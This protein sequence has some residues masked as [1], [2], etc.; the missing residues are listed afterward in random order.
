MFVALNWPADADGRP[1]TTSTIVTDGTSPRVWSYYKTKDEVFSAP[2]KVLSTGL[3]ATPPY[4]AAYHIQGFWGLM[5]LRSRDALI[6]IPARLYLAN[7]TM[8]SYL[9]TQPI[10]KA[11]GSLNSSPGSC[12]NYHNQ[13]VDTAGNISNQSFPPGFAR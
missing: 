2:G 10:V 1:S 12:I 6:P 8:E 13:A 5:G 3:A 4:P 11:D 9:Q 7:T